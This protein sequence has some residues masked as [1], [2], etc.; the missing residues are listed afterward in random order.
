MAISKVVYDNQV[1][2]DL[3]VDNTV[4]PQYLTAGKT[5]YASNGEVITGTNDFDANT[6]SGDANAAEILEGKKAWVKGEEVTGTMVN[7]GR[8][9]LF[10]IGVDDE[11]P[12]VSGY[13]DGS[14][15]ACIGDYQKATIKAENI[16]NGVNIL[17]VVGNYSG[18]SEVNPQA[19]KDVTPTANGSIVTPDTGYDYLSQVTV[20]AIPV[21]RIE[22]ER[23]AI[24][25]KIACTE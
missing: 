7:N 5:A 13:H 11:L 9:K 6:Q 4:E 16:K 22:D 17:G 15:F 21:E 20:K 10:I 18:G 1:L 12:I 19:N 23:G 24:T 3:S 14:G 8:K 25:V 2:I